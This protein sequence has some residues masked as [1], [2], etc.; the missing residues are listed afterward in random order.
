[1]SDWNQDAVN[2]SL[3]W[4]LAQAEQYL[5]RLSEHKRSGR[6]VDHLIDE[7]IAK[8]DIYRYLVDRSFSNT[9]GNFLAALRERRSW[10]PAC[11]DG[12]VDKGRA[13]RLWQSKIDALLAT[14]GTPGQSDATAKGN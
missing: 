10:G 6:M 9:R 1:M 7:Q 11:L 13:T 8:L 14:H 12:C 3:R 4:E 2:A 5:K